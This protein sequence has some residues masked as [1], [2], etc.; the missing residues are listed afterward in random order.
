[1]RSVLSIKWPKIIFVVLISIQILVMIKKIIFYKKK[2]VCLRFELFSK[3]RLMYTSRLT[4]KFF[5]NISDTKII[6]HIITN[7]KLLSCHY[8]PLGEDNDLQD[9]ELCLDFP[10]K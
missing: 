3:L 8:P 10:R 5:K 4:A 6:T 9:D 2:N 1:M 7:H